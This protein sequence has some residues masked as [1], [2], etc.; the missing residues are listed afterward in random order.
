MERTAGKAFDSQKG[1][2]KMH[3]NTHQSRDTATKI[4]GPFDRLKIYG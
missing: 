3:F 1:G 4:S 2:K